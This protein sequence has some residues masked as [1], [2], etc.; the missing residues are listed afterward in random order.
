MLQY[1]SIKGRE[2]FK[3]KWFMKRNIGKR[4]LKTLEFIVKEGDFVALKM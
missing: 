3:V 1:D 2:L 4:V